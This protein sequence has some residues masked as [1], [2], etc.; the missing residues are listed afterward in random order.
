[1]L[2]FSGHRCF[3]SAKSINIFGYPVCFSK[4]LYFASK[5]HEMGSKGR[6]SQSCYAFHFSPPPFSLPP[7]TFINGHIPP[8]QKFFWRVFLSETSLSSSPL[9]LPEHSRGVIE[10]KEKPTGGGEGNRE[11]KR[12]TKHNTTFSKVMAGGRQTLKN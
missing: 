3:R 4:W 10:G 2:K 5:M 8:A 9:P 6:R 7:A 12:F 11:G 1:M